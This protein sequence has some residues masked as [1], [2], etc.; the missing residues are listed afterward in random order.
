MNLGRQK[1][2]QTV[3]AMTSLGTNMIEDEN[4]L[5]S[6]VTEEEVLMLLNHKQKRNIPWGFIYDATVLLALV[7]L[8]VLSQ[9]AVCNS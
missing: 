1:T 7:L 8:L 9:T 4:K 2:A 3:N 5:A 6:L